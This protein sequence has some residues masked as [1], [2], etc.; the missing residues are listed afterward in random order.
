MFA[1]N[2]KQFNRIT[3]IEFDASEE[4]YQTAFKPQLW[5]TEIEDSKYGFTTTVKLDIGG[6]GI[7]TSNR[8]LRIACCTLGQEILEL[9]GMY[10]LA[11]AVGHYRKATRLYDGSLTT[12]RRRTGQSSQGYMQRE[13]K[14][15][16]ILQ[17]SKVF[18]WHDKVQAGGEYDVQG[19]IQFAVFVT[20]CKEP[21]WYD[22]ETGEERIAPQLVTRPHWF[23]TPHII[24]PEETVLHLRGL[25]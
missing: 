1:S 4:T 6:A 25:M 24:L 13:W 21:G 7:D 17:T 5:L 14:D 16:G 2:I 18:K 23:D 8:A 9:W 19:E 10:Q 11:E 3:I 15:R 22:P 12:L 20:G